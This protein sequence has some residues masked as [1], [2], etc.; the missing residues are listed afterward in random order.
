MKLISAKDD[1]LTQLFHRKVSEN[2]LVEMGVY[3]VLFGWRVRAGFVGNWMCEL[4][5]CGGSDWKNVERLYSI[6]HA[7]L[8]QRDENLE[9]FR[10]LPMFSK[11]KPFFMDLEFVDIVTKQAG[12]ISL[13][14]LDSTK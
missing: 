9:C 1:E 4:D 5:W 11:V 7:I 2:G 6:C 14:S 3:R 12:E 13:V 8:S 10:N